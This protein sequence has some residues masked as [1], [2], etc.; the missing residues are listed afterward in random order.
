MNQGL[1]R[2]AIVAK[3]EELIEHLANARGYE[4]NELATLTLTEL[5]D[6][7]RK[8]DGCFESQT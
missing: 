2:S 4:R 7:L 1:L 8:V 3:R 5:Q 6:M